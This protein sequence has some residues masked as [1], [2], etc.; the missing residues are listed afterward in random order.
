LNKRILDMLSF[1]EPGKMVSEICRNKQLTKRK[2]PSK[3]FLNT[4]GITSSGGTKNYKD[5]ATL[6]KG[7]PSISDVF[8]VKFC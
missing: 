3:D 8:E 1:P 5:G 4:G 7:L 6:Y 2:M